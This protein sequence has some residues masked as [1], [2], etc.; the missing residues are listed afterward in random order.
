[1][2]RHGLQEMDRQRIALPSREV[3]RP[4]QEYLEE[5]FVRF[6]AA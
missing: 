3:L 4:N 6:R 5:R 2:L 1:M